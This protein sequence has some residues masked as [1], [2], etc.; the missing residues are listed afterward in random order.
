MHFIRLGPL[1]LNLEQ[2]RFW[3]EIGTPPLQVRVAF[4]GEEQTVT[5]E[6][7]VALALCGYLRHHS[8][9]DLLAPLE[10]LQPRP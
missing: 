5:Y 4:V 8:G 9:P 6:G 1:G 3:E 10:A 2:I 7:E